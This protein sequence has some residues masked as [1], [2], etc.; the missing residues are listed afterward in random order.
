MIG[1][2][3]VIALSAVFFISIVMAAMLGRMIVSWFTMGEQTKI[4]SFLYV[5]TEPLIWPVRAL[6]ARFGWFTGVPFDMP[7]LITSVILSMINLFLQ[8]WMGL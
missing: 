5:V 7:F 4:G 3:Y 8:G 6:C 2:A 1:A